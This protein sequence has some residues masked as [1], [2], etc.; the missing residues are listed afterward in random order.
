MK[1]NLLCFVKRSTNSGIMLT[2]STSVMTHTKLW[3]I[4]AN[5]FMQH[6]SDTKTDGAKDW[7]EILARITSLENIVCM[8]PSARVKE[9]KSQKGEW[10]ESATTANWKTWGKSLHHGIVICTVSKTNPPHPR[11]ISKEEKRKTEEH[12]TSC[13]QTQHWWLR[14][15]Y[16]CVYLIS[17][18]N[19]FDPLVDSDLDDST[20]YTSW[21]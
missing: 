19:W 5:P 1:D 18:R 13:Q 15:W 16:Q 21:K 10:K 20:V 4:A 14:K 9:W 11:K 7:S 2:V 6:N 12:D 3:A 17:T 8:Q